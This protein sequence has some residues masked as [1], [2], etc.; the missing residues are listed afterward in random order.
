MTGGR[1]EGG[2]VFAVTDTT[3]KSLMF[4]PCISGVLEKKKTNNMH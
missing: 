4:I 2:G 1:G 3:L